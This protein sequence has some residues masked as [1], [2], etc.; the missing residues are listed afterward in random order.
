MSE[1]LLIL[2]DERQFRAASFGA[3]KFFGRSLEQL[4]GLRLDDVTEAD[5]RPQ[6]PA[7]WQSLPRQ[8]EETGKFRLITAGGTVDLGYIAVEPRT[9]ETSASLFLAGP[10]RFSGIAGDGTAISGAKER[11]L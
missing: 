11:F 8:G 1:P 2:D 9:T 10:Y 6:L 7:L 4:K 5:F 3:V